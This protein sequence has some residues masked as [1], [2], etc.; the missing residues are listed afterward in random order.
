M[1]G[2]RG[3]EQMLTGD[4][5]KGAVKGTIPT[6]P[7]IDHHAQSILIT[8]RTRF[9]LKLLRS[10]VARGSC[11]ILHAL[12]ARRLGEQGNTKVTEQDLLAS[13]NQQVLRF[14]I[15]MDEVLIVRIL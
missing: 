6:E 4:L 3:Y 12:G 1:Q 7:F 9:A 10:H 15:A 8:G 2:R 11:H 14:D 5:G 13:A